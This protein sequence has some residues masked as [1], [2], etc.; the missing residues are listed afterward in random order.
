MTRI[1][2]IG[3]MASGKTTIGNLLAQEI[4]WD[5]EDLDQTIEKRANLAIPEL[6]YRYGE[7]AFRE[8]EASALYST[9]TAINRVISTGGGAPCY[10]QNMEWMKAQGLT[11][12]LKTEP[13]TLVERLVDGPNRRPLVAN[14]NEQELESYIDKH[15]ESRRPYYEQAELVVDTQ[16]VPQ[17]IARNLAHIIAALPHPK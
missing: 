12:Y 5:F 4:L 7:Q 1:Y 11:I 6:F 17:I 16:E 3:Y 10:H 8:V 15:L 2:L 14:M 13:D 9:R